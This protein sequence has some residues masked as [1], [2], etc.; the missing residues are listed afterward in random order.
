MLLKEFSIELTAP[1]PISEKVPEEPALKLYSNPVV[2]VVK[3]QL[4]LIHAAIVPESL[5]AEKSS[6]KLIE[7]S[8]VP[9]MNGTLLGTSTVAVAMMPRSPESSKESWR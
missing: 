8:L 3:K 9:P 4:T 2:I 7:P 5:E 1:A 6:A